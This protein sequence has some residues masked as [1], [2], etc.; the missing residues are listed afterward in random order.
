MLR[1]WVVPPGVVALMADIPV[2]LCMAIC[3]TASGD[4]V[5][6]VKTSKSAGCPAPALVGLDDL[7]TFGDAV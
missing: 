1:V 5:P 6:T 2:R 4:A 3:P 7:W